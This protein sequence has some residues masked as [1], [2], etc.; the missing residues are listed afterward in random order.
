MDVPSDEVGSTLGFEKILKE[1]GM[2]T[3][4]GVSRSQR[5]Q[6]RRTFWG[7]HRLHLGVSFQRFYR[8]MWME[9]F[10]RY[11]FSRWYLLWFVSPFF[12]F[13]MSVLLLDEGGAGTEPNRLVLLR[14][15]FVVAVQSFFGAIYEASNLYRRFR[16]LLLVSPKFATDCVG[17]AVLIQLPMLVLQIEVA[18]AVARSSSDLNSRA[19]AYGLLWGLLFT[20]IFVGSLI[21]KVLLW[22]AILWLDV[23]YTLRHLPLAAVLVY[24]LFVSKHV[25]FIDEMP[26]FDQVWIQKVSPAP[27]ALFGFLLPLI[28]LA[29]VGVLALGFQAWSKRVLAE[30][31]SDVVLGRIGADDDDLA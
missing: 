18:L 4:V 5:A 24:V 12:V 11:R 16:K 19:L 22:R 15:L 31:L 21:G 1:T 29:P 28:F 10:R 3:P 8:L 14:L 25:S 27:V 2:Q 17:A 13:L 30:H 9:Y 6:R 7:R 20:E 23:R 26:L